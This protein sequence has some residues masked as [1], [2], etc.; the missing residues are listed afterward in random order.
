MTTTDLTRTYAGNDS[1]LDILTSWTAAEIDSLDVDERATLEAYCDARRAVWHRG[2]TCPDTV[3]DSDWDEA[4]GC[5]DLDLMPW[6][7]D[8]LRSG[9][10][11]EQYRAVDIDTDWLGPARHSLSEAQGDARDR[12]AA[13]GHATV[14]C[15][16]GDIC[17]GVQTGC[18]WRSKD[19]GEPVRW[20]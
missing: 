5:Q 7:T 19:T 15:R 4:C 10:P 8:I 16:D 17:L 13:G 1:T 20:A 14:V 11:R 9:A 12:N 3:A 18:P 2:L 6:A